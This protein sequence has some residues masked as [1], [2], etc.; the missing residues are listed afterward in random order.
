VLRAFAQAAGEV[1]RGQERMG[2]YGG[3]E[4]LLVMPGTGM[5]ELTVVFERLRQQL[6]AQPIHGLPHPHGVTLSMGAAALRESVESVEV[7]VDEADRQL[8]RAKAEGR[9]TLRHGPVE[10]REPAPQ[11]A[12]AER[13]APASQVA[14]SA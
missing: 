14:V 1:L 3:D 5:N 7:L 10:A 2:R 9:N 8:Y 4:W 12:D 11:A 13:E 6:A